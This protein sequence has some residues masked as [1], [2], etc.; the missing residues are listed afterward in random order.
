MLESVIGG[1]LGQVFGGRQGGMSPLVKALLMLLLSKGASGG[2]GDIFGKG[3][4]GEPGPEADRSGSGPS[5]GASPEPTRQGNSGDIG[6]YDQYGGR[7]DTGPVG[8]GS[9][10]A[11]P[12]ADDSLPGSGFDDLSGMLG[13]GDASSSPA[14]P[15]PEEIGGLGP[16]AD[17]FRQAG[18]GHVIESWIGH[19]GNHAIAPDQLA[20]ALGDDTVTSLEKE[21]GMERGTLLAELSQALPEV[22]HRLTPG[23]Q[24]P[25]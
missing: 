7:R 8:R 18:L 4:Q 15:D 1:V 24:L 5:G 13:G 11:E 3:R 25:R 21:T 10:S 9:D 14:R 22:V 23:G 19:G 16:L 6:G 17:R 12:P 2:F 20:Q